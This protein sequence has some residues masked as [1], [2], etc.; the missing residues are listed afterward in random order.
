MKAFHFRLDAA[1]R[2]RAARLRLEREAAAQASARV[3]ALQRELI[4]TYTGLRTESTRLASVGSPAFATWSAYLDRS[5]RQIRALEEQSLAARKALAAATKAT[6]EAHRNLRVLED[7]KRDQLMA[8]NQALNRETEAFASEAFLA[9]L[10]RDERK[11]GRSASRGTI[12]GQTDPNH[13]GA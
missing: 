5:R 2:W 13:T 12:E 1:L 3:A 10:Q 8:W 11:T 6:V 4:A 7:M 9:R